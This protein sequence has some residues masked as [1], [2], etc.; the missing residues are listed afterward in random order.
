MA[1]PS[2]GLSP[3]AAMV[4]DRV[5]EIENPANP[6]SAPNALLPNR[7]ARVSKLQAA[8][9]DLVGRIAPLQSIPDTE[10]D[11][12]FEALKR[13]LIGAST[14]FPQGLCQR[15]LNTQI[16]VNFDKEQ[17]ISW[18]ERSTRRSPLHKYEVVRSC[19]A[20][21]AQNIVNQI[22]RIEG[23]RSRAELPTSAKEMV[24]QIVVSYD[25]RTFY[26]R[27]TYFFDFWG[28]T[29]LFLCNETGDILG[30]ERQSLVWSS[31]SHR[32]EIAHGIPHKDWPESTQN[33]TR[34]IFK[35]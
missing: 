1:A 16:F 7:A 6:T 23:V 17:G 18:Y 3:F 28:T 15:T 35:E 8:V 19:G 32:T 33:N 26:G 27:Q 13:M 25:D 31:L 4:I 34:R 10:Y 29:I 24:D 12:E 30:Y 14:S 11:C 21:K 20:H 22:L 5:I 2:R 9:R